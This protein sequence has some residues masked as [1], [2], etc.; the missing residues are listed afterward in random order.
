MARRFRWLAT[1]STCT[2]IMALSLGPAAAADKTKVEDSTRQITEGA[3]SI[4]YG[5]FGPGVSDVIVGTGR[6]II[7]GTVYVG[8]TIGEFF[9]KAFGD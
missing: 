7:H 5:E 3:Q 8:K 4:G 9:K 2:L 6:T 1:V